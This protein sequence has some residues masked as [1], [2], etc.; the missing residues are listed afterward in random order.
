MKKHI[1]LWF[2]VL[3]FSLS[4]AGQEVPRG[5][6]FGSK[7]VKVKFNDVVDIFGDNM[8]LYDPE[9]NMLILRDGFRY[10]LPEGFVSFNTGAP[11]RI[12]L[13]GK[14]FIEAAVVSKDPVRI[15]SD[16][17]STLTIVSNGSTTA[18]KCP[19]LVIEDYMTSVRL[20]SDAP[21]KEMIALNCPGEVMV[22]GGALR[23]E[24]SHSAKAA[25]IHTL[26]LN[27]SVLETP[28][29]ITINPN[30]VVCDDK[31]RYVRLISIIPEP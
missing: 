27:G 3:S 14:A 6:F 9:M 4:V 29:A 19:Q 18:L 23:M 12:R 1:V 28:R 31:G 16:G 7:P 17:Y 2:L 11:L 25:E 13:E 30:G 5:I 20:Y 24:V 22:N 15:E 10:R 21:N 26:T 8:A